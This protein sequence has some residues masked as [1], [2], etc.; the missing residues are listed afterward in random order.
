VLKIGQFESKN[1]FTIFFRTSGVVNISYLDKGKTKDYQTYI[2][3]WLNPLVSTLKGKNLMYGTKNLKLFHFSA[4][5][6][7][8]KDVKK[9]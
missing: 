1:M 6:H 9:Y 8:Q 3:V 4:R 2:E 7:V 5:P